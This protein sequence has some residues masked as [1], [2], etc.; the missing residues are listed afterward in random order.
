VTT[1][2]ISD[3]PTAERIRYA[4]AISA[5]KAD[6]T[7]VKC[8]DG[9]IVVLVKDDIGYRQHYSGYVMSNVPLLPIEFYTAHYVRTI[10]VVKGLDAERPVISRKI[11][12]SLYAVFMGLGWWR[13]RAARRDT[14]HR[15]G[16]T[17]ISYS[18]KPCC[19]ERSLNAMRI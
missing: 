13:C 15:G 4:A 10:I 7:A 17:T 18:V 9:R 2:E 16:S 1:P 8:A 11:S 14:R 3:G 12:P 19:V 6:L 5:G